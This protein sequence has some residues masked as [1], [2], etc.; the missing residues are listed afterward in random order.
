MNKKIIGVLFFAMLFVMWSCGGKEEVVEAVEL[1]EINADTQ[2][3]IVIWAWNVAAK[4]LQA[5]VPMFNEKYPNIKVTVEEYGT[6]P[7]EKYGVV[8]NSLEGMPDIAAMESDFVHTYAETYP[9]AFLDMTDLVPDNWQDLVDPSKI[10][11]SY[12]SE[13][14]LVSIP[15]DSGPV[16]MFYRAD[17]FEEAGIDPHTIETYD[18][19]IAAGKILQ[20]KLPD[21][22]MLGF[23]FTQDDGIWRTLMVQNGSYYLTP[24]GD[25]AINSDEAVEAMTILKRF[26]DEDIVM[27]TVNWDGSIRASKLGQIASAISGGWWAGTLKDQMPE[28]AGKFKAMRIP[29][30]ESGETRSSS[31]GGSTLMITATDPIKRAASWAFVEMALLSENAQL[32]MYNNFG[33]FP[34]YLPTYQTQEFL[35]PDPY[36]AGQDYNKLLGD[37]TKDIPPVL[38]NSDDYSEIRNIGVSTFENIINSDV[39]IKEALDDAAAQINSSTGRPIAK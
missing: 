5:V 31:L 34:S 35:Q 30:F 28:L 37:V 9:Q 18:D 2:T 3:E 15:W 13:G 10:P 32:I 39:D 23:G 21:V 24:N 16:V 27:D 25:I 6:Q 29:S 26:I 4:G 7:Y 22:K 19:Y 38:Y 1:P 20:E 8:F 17:M 12:D 36:F 14:R 11:T 33:L